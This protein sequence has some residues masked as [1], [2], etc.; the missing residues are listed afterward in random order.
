VAALTS[1]STPRDLETG[2]LE[3]GGATTGRCGAARLLEGGA[4]P[5]SLEIGRRRGATRH[6]R[7]RVA[8]RCPRD[9]D[10]AARSSLQVRVLDFSGA[11]VPWRESG[12]TSHR[13]INEL[14]VQ[15]VTA[16]RPKP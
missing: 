8:A 15:T 6:S 7:V 4:A 12:E 3:G 10:G 14:R 1:S 13:G 5:W 16:N 2:S 11:R 9:Y